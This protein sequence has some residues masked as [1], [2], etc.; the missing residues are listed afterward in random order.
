MALPVVNTNEPGVKELIQGSVKEI[1]NTIFA[2]ANVSITAAAKAVTPSIPEMI[3]DITEDLRAGPVNRFSQGLEKLDK[4]LQNFGGDIKDYSAELAKF[5]DQREARIDKS[6]KTIRELR[7]NNVKA[8]ITSMGEINILSKFQIGLKEKELKAADEVIKK[9]I[10]NVEKKTKLVQEENGNTKDRRNSI[11]KSQNTII[12]KE[13]ERTQ[14]L[15]VLN[16]TEEEDKRGFFE[17]LGDGINEYVPDGLSDVGSAFTE[18]LMQPI[19]AVKDLGKMFGSILKFGKNLPK[20]LKG[21]AAGLMGALMAMIP[22]LLI[23]GAIVIALIAL[24]KGFDLVVDNLDVIKQKLSDFGDAV[25]AIPGKIADFFSG[26]FTKVKNF[27]IDAIN[28][29]IDLINKFKPGKDIEKI[30]K[31]PVPSEADM[32]PGEQDSAF[33]AGN[34]DNTSVAEAQDNAFNVVPNT[35]DNE[36][37]GF[38]SKFKNMF[39]SKP[40]NNEYMPID[41]QTQSGGNTIID[42]SVK[43]ANQ[44]NTTQSTGLSSRNDDATIFRTSDVAV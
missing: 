37:E 15:E 28:G 40:A 14:L 2:A 18:G 13:K 8:E 44:S 19:N 4:L 20:L 10:Q 38:F 32:T 25:M 7:E 34:L 39:K 24:K 29:V 27:F 30:A 11:L 35:S 1:A 36:G 16:R 41:K 17:R 3:G 31:D 26:I 9:E 22:Y 5:V 42:N 21:F 33:T 23:A 6:E 43:T 12:E